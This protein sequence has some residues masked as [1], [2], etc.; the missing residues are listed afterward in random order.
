[1]ERLCV[2][3]HLVGREFD[4]Y[5]VNNES[6]ALDDQVYTAVEDPDDG[7]RSCL[8]SVV[9]EHDL[10]TMVFSRRSL[11]RVR[12]TEEDTKD[13]YGDGVMT[14]RLTDVDTGHCWLEF[15]T[16]NY[17]DWYPCFFFSYTPVMAEVEEA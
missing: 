4:F 6:F 3:E 15:G 9:A 1:M 11:G 5:G 13:A 2:L 16:A 17:D 12:V 14:W 8:D 7:Y 10:M